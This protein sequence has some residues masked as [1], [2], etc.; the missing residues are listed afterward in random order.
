[1]EIR[2]QKIISEAG[3][4]SRRKAEE[5]ILDGR[6]SVNNKT[7]SE[8]GTKANPDKDIIKVNGK[9]IDTNKPKIYI[10]LNKPFGIISSR[11]DEK[12]R[13]TVVDL[14]NTDEYIYPIGRL[15]YDSSG[16]ILL[17]NDGEITNNLI[18]PKYEVEKVYVVYIQ[19]F[20]P[21]RALEKFE[22]GIRLED[23]YTAPAKVEIIREENNLTILE[24]TI[25]EGKNR[26]IRRMF[27]AL[28]YE[29]TKLK[30]IRIGN[31]KLDNLKAGEYRSLT[32][33]EIK[34][35]KSLKK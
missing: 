33:E 20:I 25:H 32:N 5:L 31:I 26:Q 10:A 16:L 3:I 14:I 27:D 28:G 11:K 12:D 34:W 9:K 22:K 18:H 15:D 6:V 1:M 7:V 35:I 21:D 2:L 19:G 17:T 30:R 13:E 23:G 24:V 8:L 4:A 29:V